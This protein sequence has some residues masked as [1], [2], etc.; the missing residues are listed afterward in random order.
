MKDKFQKWIEKG[1][2]QGENEYTKNFAV[3]NVADWWIKTFRKR[4]K[5]ANTVFLFE[6]SGKCSSLHRAHPENKFEAGWNAAVEAML[7]Y[8]PQPTMKEY[9]NAIKSLKN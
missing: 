4:L 2:W 3:G 6:T 1:V 9:E 5:N 8:I 7:K